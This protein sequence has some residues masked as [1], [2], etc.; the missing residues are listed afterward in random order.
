MIGPGV[1]G[2]RFERF[3]KLKVHL[4]LISESNS[5]MIQASQSDDRMRIS[6]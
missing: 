1:I 5:S 2:P 4:S 6:F 3:E